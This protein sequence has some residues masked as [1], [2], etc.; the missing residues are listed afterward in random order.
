M[1]HSIERGIVLPNLAAAVS[2][3]G[4]AIPLRL[5]RAGRSLSKKSAVKMVATEF[6]ELSSA[7]IDA[8]KID[9]HAQ[10][11]TRKESDFPKPYRIFICK[12]GQNNVYYISLY[13]FQI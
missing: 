11:S 4:S 8:A 13:S 1:R 10:V 7:D 2:A 9:D 6:I 3:T 12:N 5:A